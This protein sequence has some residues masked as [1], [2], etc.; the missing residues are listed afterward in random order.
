MSVE[1]RDVNL[2]HETQAVLAGSRRWAVEQ[3]D[4]L[5]VLRTLPDGCVQTCV[6]S[7]PYFQLRDYKCDGQIG[8]EKTPELYIAKLVKVFAEVRRV[9][10][11]D[12]TLWIN[13]GDSYAAHGAGGAGKELA[14]QG[15]D[16]ISRKARKPPPGLKPKDLIG[17][18][19][20]LAFALRDDGWYLRSEIIWH[21]PS[22]MPESVGDRPTKAH[23]Q[24]FLL[25]KRAKY[26]Y[27]AQA[28]K[29]PVQQSSLARVAQ[30]D[31]NP[32]WD[33]IRERGFPGANPQ[34]MNIARMVD[35]A[36]RN[37]R[38]VWT[39]A[40][41]SFSGSHFAVMP[42]KLVAPCV[43]AGTS[44]RGCCPSCGSPWLRATEKSRTATRPAKVSK[45]A[46]REILE[47]GNRDRERHVSTSRTT[48]WRQGCECPG[49]E[50]IPCLVLDP[51]SGAG[52]VVMVANQLGRR[53]LGIELNP[54]YVEM[55]R[56]RITAPEAPIAADADGPS[57]FG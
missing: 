54:E 33:G 53:G 14:Y 20:T 23:E 12:A 10:R 56:R 43:L 8:L 6:T 44:E 15:G 35:P 17:I 5:D 31:G 11:D 49:H 36:G 24:L 46:G 50:P 34:T 29:E 45:V 38:S 55:S 41:E 7:H 40:A 32:K 2:S 9:M 51:F 30:N 22:P 25:T 37:R 42:T 19:W 47:V 28:I 39:I 13:C 4:C 1:V 26:Y 18:P 52:T 27:D 48:G 16:I 57:L 21:K 3:G